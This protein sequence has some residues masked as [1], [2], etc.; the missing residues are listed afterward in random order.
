VQVAGM[1]RYRLGDIR[2]WLFV[3]RPNN[4]REISALTGT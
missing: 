1:P 2:V 4:R 3:D